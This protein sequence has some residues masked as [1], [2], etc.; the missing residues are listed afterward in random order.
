MSIKCPSPG[1]NE[2]FSS[3]FIKELVNESVFN[4]YKKEKQEFNKQMQLNNN[5]IIFQAKLW[6]ETIWDNVQGRVMLTRTL[7]STRRCPSCSFVIEKNGGCDHMTCR[8]C[9]TE[10]HWCCGMRYY[11]DTHN[12]FTCFLM[13]YGAIIL[14][15]SIILASSTA[16]QALIINTV[17]TIAVTIGYQLQNVPTFLYNII[18]AIVFRGLLPI[19]NVL[20]CDTVLIFI[21]TICYNLPTNN[22]YRYN[23]DYYDKLNGGMIVFLVLVLRFLLPSSNYI[24]SWFITPILSMVATTAYILG[25]FISLL[26]HFLLNVGVLV[27]HVIVFLFN[28]M[29]VTLFIAL[30]KLLFAVTVTAITNIFRMVFTIIWSFL[31]Y[32]RTPFFWLLLFLQTVAMTRIMKVFF[33]AFIHMNKEYLNGNLHSFDESSAQLRRIEWMDVSNND[34]VIM[35]YFKKCIID[36]YNYD[37]DQLVDVNQQIIRYNRHNTARNYSLSKLFNHDFIAFVLGFTGP[38]TSSYIQLMSSPYINGIIALMIQVYSGASM[39]EMFAFTYFVQYIFYFIILYQSDSILELWDN[40]RNIPWIFSTKIH[41]VPLYENQLSSNGKQ[42][43]H[44]GYLLDKYRQ[45]FVLLCC[46][47]IVGYFMPSIITSINVLWSM[48]VPVIGFVIDLIV[49]NCTILTGL[50]VLMLGVYQVVT[51]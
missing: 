49:N 51:Y 30:S 27:G 9:R 17:T 37:I 14:F 4:A 2:V 23:Q 1:C 19:L 7:Q 32:I 38:T 11:Y 8:K 34:H 43:Y 31:P 48:M 22:Y 16:I 26:V 50:V 24:I 21:A 20:L 6:C 10:F 5:S 36:D 46:M 42:Y 25:H 3:K 45:L 15:I 29:F 39:I 47:L 40:Y 41:E 35:Q 44:Y 33:G 13:K 12:P 18:H 28:N